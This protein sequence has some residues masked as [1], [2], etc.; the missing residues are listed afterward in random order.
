MRALKL[1]IP[2]AMFGAC[3]TLALCTGPELIAQESESYALTRVIGRHVYTLDHGLTFRDCF[4]IL[5]IDSNYACERE[6]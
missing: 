6:R 1:A 4:A 3:L 5:P 2:A